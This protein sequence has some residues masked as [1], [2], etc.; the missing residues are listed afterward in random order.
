LT[1]HLRTGAGFALVGVGVLG[2][3]LPVIPGVPLVIA[4]LA[5]LGREHPLTRAIETRIRAWRRGADK[6]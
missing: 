1:K 4:G 3:V 6:P 5:L 2:T